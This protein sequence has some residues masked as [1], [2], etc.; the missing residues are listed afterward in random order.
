M[1]QHKKNRGS[2]KRA[3]FLAA[4]ATT[5]NIS[6]AAEIAEISRKSHYRWLEDESYVSA[7]DDAHEQACDSLEQEARRRAAEGVEEPVFYQGKEVGTVRRY[8]DTLLIFLLKGAMP[9]K[10]KDRVEQHIKGKGILGGLS[11]EELERIARGGS[12]GASK[13]SAGSAE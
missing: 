2:G 6:R 13:A 4:Y 10:Y 9:E 8:S 1:T 7:F 5:G 12:S 11:D 3:A